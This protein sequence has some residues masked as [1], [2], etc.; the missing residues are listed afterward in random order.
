MPRGMLHKFMVSK[1]YKMVRILYDSTQP[2]IDELIIFYPGPSCLPSFSCFDPKNMSI[3]IT[4]NQFFWFDLVL[5][6]GVPNK[7]KRPK[8]QGPRRIFET[9][10]EA[11]PSSLEEFSSTFFVLSR[12]GFDVGRSNR[13]REKKRHVFI[14]L[15]MRY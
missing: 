1:P 2:P 14:G 11:L 4:L 9:S 10:L 8:N 6:P 13:P 15:Q 7:K 3:P 12:L 5:P